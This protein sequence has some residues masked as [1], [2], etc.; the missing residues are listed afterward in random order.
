ML[1]LSV[2]DILIED[3]RAV[4]V[5]VSKGDEPIEIRAKTIVSAG[6]VP[7]TLK[8]L[9]REVAEKTSKHIG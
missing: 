6:G 2:T 3:G 9:P 8:L 1:F 7:N 4:G 5:R